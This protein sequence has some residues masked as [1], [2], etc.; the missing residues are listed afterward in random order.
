[1]KEE[2]I[3]GNIDD[4]I[5]IQRKHVQDKNRILVPVFNKKVYPSIMRFEYKMMPCSI[6]PYG[7]ATYIQF[8]HPDGILH[9]RDIFCINGDRSQKLAITM[10]TDSGNGLV[11]FAQSCDGNGVDISPATTNTEFIY[12]NTML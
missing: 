2:L 5:V 11:F 10:C 1:M 9:Y 3:R 8:R 4:I 12:L 6:P 7:K